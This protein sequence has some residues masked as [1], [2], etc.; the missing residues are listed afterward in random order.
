MAAAKKDSTGQIFKASAIIGGASAVSM[1]AGVIRNKAVAV[2]LGPESIGLIGLLQSVM[3]TAGTIA[4][5][6]MA[7]SGV[8]QI[9][10]AQ[11][12]G[13]A[14]C[15][16]GT[17]KALLWSS[18]ILGLFGAGLLV[19]LRQPVASLVFGHAGYAGAIAWVGAGVWASTASGAHISILNGL[20]RLGDLARAY[21]LGALGGMFLTVPAVWLWGGNGV[22]VAVISTPLALLLASWWYNLKIPANGYKFARENIVRTLRGLLGLGFAFMSANLIRQANQL[23]VRVV[24]TRTLGLAA[25]GYFQAA[26]SISMLYLGFVLDAM[27]KDFYPRLSAVARERDTT[28]KMVNEQIKILLLLAG[29][30]ILG[31]LTLTPQVINTIYSGAFAETIGILQ[32]QLVGDLFKV[33]SWPMGFILVAQERV[34]LIIT[35]EIFWNLI[36]LGLIW[37]GLP[38]WNLK[39]TGV[40]YFATYI[41]YFCLLVLIVFRTNHFVYRKR[42]LLLLAILL[43]CAAIITLARF[44][45]GIFPL[46]LGLTVTAAA[47]GFSLLIISRSLGG[48]PW[49]KKADRT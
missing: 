40:A 28:N 47:G 10:E 6:G 14:K 23:V 20:R 2:L 42:N 34:R 27:G 29:P 48:L 36:F 9:A 24:I 49:K 32:W 37:G 18:A 11:A 44:L 25:A 13:D 41:F 35:M 5:M 33:A 46:A 16:A 39:I 8:R 21:V 7:S 12:N 4:G 38:A 31:M 43:G 26:W 45:P 1:I 30:V 19:L 3:N 22:I 17:R 15:V